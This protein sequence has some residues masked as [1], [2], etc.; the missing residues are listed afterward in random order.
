[1]K[2]KKIY[3]WRAYISL[4]TSFFLLSR[5]EKRT[6]I[7]IR[8]TFFWNGSTSTIIQYS[9]QESGKMTRKV[10]GRKQKNR[11]I[12]LM[13]YEYTN[14]NILDEYM[15]LH[16]MFFCCSS[17]WQSV[18]E[19]HSLFNVFLPFSVFFFTIE[20]K[21]QKCVCVIWSVFGENHLRNVASVYLYCKE[22]TV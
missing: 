13:R 2:E 8:R 17:Q 15:A 16:L 9:H 11:V 6:K 7:Y 5:I 4:F 21:C 18:C 1:M 20:H 14:T 22:Y 12:R 19:V 10:T 3:A